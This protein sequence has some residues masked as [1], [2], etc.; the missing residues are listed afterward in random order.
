[1]KISKASWLILAAGI[2]IIILAGLGVTRSGQIKQFDTL[3]ENLSITTAR[4]N[5]LQVG[6][7]QT[8]INEYQEQVKDTLSQVAEVSDKLKQTVISVDVAD[9]FYEIAEYCGVIV[10]NMGTTPVSDQKYAKIDCMT[11]SVNAQISGTPEGIVKF[12]IAINDN[13]STGF[14]RAAQLH[15]MPDDIS[16]VSLQMIVYTQKGS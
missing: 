1:M 12:V 10:T 7:L 16:T 14:V 9:K 15:F 6:S 4:L 3:S 11:T 5:N 2:F 13:F 8:E